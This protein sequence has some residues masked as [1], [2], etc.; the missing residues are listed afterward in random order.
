MCDW[1][2]VSW[3]TP[4]YSIKLLHIVLVP[5]SFFFVSDITAIPLVFISSTSSHSLFPIDVTFHAAIFSVSHIPNCFSFFVPG[6]LS[7]DLPISEAVRLLMS[8]LFPWE[9][10]QPIH[11]TPI[12]G[13]PVYLS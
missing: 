2:C 6:H 8:I 12:L 7:F 9:G 11:K 5:F 1:A 10:Y 3:E 13:G 4:L